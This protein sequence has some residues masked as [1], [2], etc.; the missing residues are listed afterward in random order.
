MSTLQE[1]HQRT[2]TTHEHDKML[3]TLSPL[4]DCFGINHF[5]WMRIIPIDGS[6]YFHGLGSNLKWHEF[7]YENIKALTPYPHIQHPDNLQTEAI[8]FQGSDDSPHKRLLEIAWQQFKIHFVLNIQRKTTDGIESFGFGLK[9]RHYR[10]VQHLLN[11]LPLIQQFNEYFL[12]ENRKLIDLSYEFQV[13][14]AS[15][16]GPQFFEKS[17]S[18]P[19]GSHESLLKQLGLEILDTLSRRE[20]EVLQFVAHGYPASYIA[21]QLH[22]SSR[23]VEH[24]IDSLKSKLG[25]DSKISLIKMANNLKITML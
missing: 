18:Y 5:Y 25:C 21:E 11:H 8:L 14:I 4:C 13:D 15:F 6:W 20:R 23:T 24:H 22:L 3:R 17:Q 1:L 16:L 7:F 9:S 19:C 10:G 2:T 12:S